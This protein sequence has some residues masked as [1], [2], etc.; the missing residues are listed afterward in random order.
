MR[1]SPDAMPAAHVGANPHTDPIV[2][3]ASNGVRA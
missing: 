3:A 2:D 1:G